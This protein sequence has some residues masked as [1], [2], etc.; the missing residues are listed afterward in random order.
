MIGAVAM[1][2]EHAVGHAEL[3]RN[4][5]GTDEFPHYLVS[6]GYLEQPAG[7][8]FGYQSVAVGQALRPAGEVGEKET[9]G[10]P[11]YCHTI[12]LVDG[13]TSMTRE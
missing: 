12:S 2:S 6:G 4:D 10:R 7:K 13:S 11:W 5:E 3:G 1:G 8:T 9:I